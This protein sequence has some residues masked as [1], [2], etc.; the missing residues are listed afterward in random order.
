MGPDGKP[1]VLF[2]IAGVP[3]LAALRDETAAARIASFDTKEEADSAAHAQGWSVRDET[4]PN[5]RCFDCW[6]QKRSQDH[7]ASTEPPA[8]GAYICT[9][10][11]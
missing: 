6:N 9:Q 4:G 3:N 5:H 1:D 7:R 2:L 10:G 11:L 8:R